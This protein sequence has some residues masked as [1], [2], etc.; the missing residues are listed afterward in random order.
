[1]TEWSDDGSEPAVRG[2]HQLQTWR[3]VWATNS[4]FA[5]WSSSVSVRHLLFAGLHVRYCCVGRERYSGPNRSSLPAIPRG[6]MDAAHRRRDVLSGLEAV[7]QR[8][9]V[10][11]Q[12]RG[13]VFHRLS[14]QPH[15]CIF[16]RR[17]I[18]RTKRQGRDDLSECRLPRTNAAIRVFARTFGT[19][20]ASCRHPR[21][22]RGM[23][24]SP[25][26]QRHVTISRSRP[27]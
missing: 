15:G 10:V 4:S 21:Q 14:I 17:H 3:A 16:P 9:E 22:A 20:R 19:F 11:L 25:A 1:M 8:L 12:M 24:D 7:E 23:G 2:R 26:S 5:H 27:R 6:N 18:G 13:V